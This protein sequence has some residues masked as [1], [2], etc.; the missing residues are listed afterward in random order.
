MVTVHYVV[1]TMPFPPSTPPAN[2]GNTSQPGQN[3]SGQTNIWKD[4]SKTDHST[5]IDNVGDEKMPSN[6][7]N[8]GAWGKGTTLDQAEWHAARV[9]EVNY[10]DSGD[11]GSA[12]ATGSTDFLKLQGRVYGDTGYKDGTLMASGGVQGRLELVGSHY[13]A[14]YTSPTLF[15]FGGHD[16]RSQT[17][18]NADASVGVTGTVE[19]GIG[20]GKSD[21]VK[22]GASGFAGASASIKGSETLGDVAGV[23]GDASVYAGIGAKADLDAGYKDGELSFNFGAGIAWGFGYSFDFGFSINVGAIG[24]GIEDGAKWVGNEAEDAAKA[25][26]NGAEDAAKAVGNAVGDAASAVGDAISDVFDW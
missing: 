18:V 5:S 13:Q 22:V 16:I 11:W 20:L 9:G 15:S 6:V 23:N 8:L 3:A 24:D 4:S 26:G 7:S 1:P 25:V 14:G 21:Y 2:P 10:Q 19:G 12:Y 17:N